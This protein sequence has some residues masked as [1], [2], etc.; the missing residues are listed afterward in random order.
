M[1]LL[2][3][4]G[5]AALDTV[6]PVSAEYVGNGNGWLDPGETGSLFVTLNNI[7]LSNATA[8]SATLS[9]ST[10]GVTIAPSATQNYPDL[11]PAFG[12]A[13][14]ATPFAF[15]LSTSFPCGGVVSFTLTVN[16][17]G[18]GG[19]QVFNFDV[20]TGRPTAVSTTLDV[21]APPADPTYTA[22]TGAQTGRLTRNGVPSSCSSAKA[23]PG[24][25]TTTG[26]R[27][28]DAYTFTAS[29]SG[30]TTVTLSTATGNMFA[31]AYNGSGFVPSNPN[32]N[33]LADAGFSDVTTEFSFSVTAGQHYTVVVHEVDPAGGVGSNY[34]LNVSGPISG[35]CQIAIPTAATVKIA[36]RVLTQN[37]KG[38]HKA[39][40]TLTDM[41]GQ[42]R[43]VKTNPFGAYSFKGLVA[44]Q[45]YTVNAAAKG[46]TFV[47]RFITPKGDLG[48]VDFIAQ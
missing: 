31:A 33:Y 35:G 34:S 14:N 47:T 46:Y 41:N 3:V 30:C 13:T 28:F 9:T 21:T 11:V 24:L 32:T 43:S 44:G 8:I 38:I 5:P 42:T 26:S 6:P 4:S 19:T 2:G 25:F 23:A 17:T 45:S 39:V 37:G 15:N 7:G 12:S 29:G 36:G 16:Y 27:Q 40:V 20:N 18:G 48:D 10:P 1:N 22:I